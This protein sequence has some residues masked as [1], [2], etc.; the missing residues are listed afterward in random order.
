MRLGILADIHEDEQKLSLAL[1]HF[2]R[3]GAEQ[4]V[5]L[6]DV[7][8]TGRRLRETVALLAEAGAVGV[9]GNHDLG[10]C[11]EPEERVRRR[12]AGPALDYLGT[13]LPRIELAGCLFTHGLPHWDATDPEVY[14]LGARPE[15]AE[16]LS[17]TFGASGHAAYFVGHFHRWLAASPQGCLAWEGRTPILL[18]PDRRY[19]VAVAAVCDGWCAVYHTD[20][21][22]LVPHRVAAR[23]ERNHPP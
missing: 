4:V 11:H 3:Q 23:Y 16:G 15:T 1:Q 19:L 20:R 12:Y 14:Y 2:R 13:L 17:G 5:V 21:R 18:H 9:W 22:E 6:G 8:D 7:F 10:L